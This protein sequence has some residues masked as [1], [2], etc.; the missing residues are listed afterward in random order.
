MSAESPAITQTMRLLDCVDAVRHPPLP[1]SPAAIKTHLMEVCQGLRQPLSGEEADQA[2]ALYLSP[3]AVSTVS[4]SAVLGDRPTSEAQ[5]RQRIEIEA[6]TLRRLTARVRHWEKG[7]KVLACTLP[8]LITMVAM[9]GIFAFCMWSLSVTV[10]ANDTAFPRHHWGTWVLATA[11]IAFGIVQL[12][13]G[14]RL[15]NWFRQKKERVTQQ[16]RVCKELQPASWNM[17]PTQR[18]LSSW[19]KRPGVPAAFFQIH[20][21]GVPWLEQDVT[22][23]QRHIHRMDH[24]EE[25]RKTEEQDR[26]REEEWQQGFQQVLRAHAPVTP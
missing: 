7:M 24:D 26:R 21:S 1:E 17:R 3:E 6:A 4:P 18:V 25:R 22:A 8:L 2:V 9:S 13:K 23:L 14:N 11:T 19:A 16:Q 5:W 12:M 20:A 10:A 15:G